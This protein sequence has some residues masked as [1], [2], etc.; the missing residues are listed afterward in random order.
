M[1]LCIFS[2]VLIWF[3]TFFKCHHFNVYIYDKN[4]MLTQQCAFK[5]KDYFGFLYLYLTNNLYLATW[6]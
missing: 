2:L 6:D 5:K 3:V 4:L 1:R